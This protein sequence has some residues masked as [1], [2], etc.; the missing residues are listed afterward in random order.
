MRENFL[1]S[2]IPSRSAEGRLKGSTN[3]EDQMK[4]EEKK[5]GHTKGK[6]AVTEMMVK[7]SVVANGGDLYYQQITSGSRAVMGLLHD[8]SPEAKANLKLMAAAPDLLAAAENARNVLAGL[9]NG[10]LKDIKENSPALQTLREAIAKAKK[11][12][13]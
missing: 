12:A 8:G 4:T 6:W 7:R 9:L 2:A 10:D 3:R 13:T 1:I 11:V 5:A